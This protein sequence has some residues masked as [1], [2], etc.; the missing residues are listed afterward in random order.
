MNVYDRVLLRIEKYAL[1]FSAV[2][3]FFIIVSTVFS[4][5]IMRVGDRDMVL[6]KPKS[7]YGYSD[8][9]YDFENSTT[10]PVNA[11][12]A[13]AN[14]PAIVSNRTFAQQAQAVSATN[15]AQRNTLAPTAAPQTTEAPSTPVVTEPSELTSAHVSTA[16]SSSQHIT[17]IA[18]T[19][20]ASSSSA[21]PSSTATIGPSTTKVKPPCKLSI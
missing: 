17:T 10:N 2:V 14:S 15:A 4:T 6:E 20:T 12:A 19:S 5:S 13:L 18:A 7:H 3:L 11:D 16:A 9:I 21:S 1:V 8:D